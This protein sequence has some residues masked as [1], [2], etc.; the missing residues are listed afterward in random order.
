MN[1][2]I[3]MPDDRHEYALTL[4]T[5]VTTQTGQRVY[6]IR[7]ELRGLLLR[8]N[9]NGLETKRFA[10]EERMPLTPG[11]YNVQVTL[12]NTRT[13]VALRKS[14]NFVVPDLSSNSFNISNLVAFSQHVDENIGRSY[15]SPLRESALIHAE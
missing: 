10:V 9:F 3:G 2:F 15:L 13:H 8:E 4:A 11:P 6:Q 14:Q 7:N 12:T 1:E 5:T